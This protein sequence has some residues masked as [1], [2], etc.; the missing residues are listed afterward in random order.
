MQIFLQGQ[1]VIPKDIPE[2]FLNDNKQRYLLKVNVKPGQSYDK[3]FSTWQELKEYIIPRDFYFVHAD[4]NV[5]D[6]AINLK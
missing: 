1:D 2:D 6:L 3:T 5:Y 4:F